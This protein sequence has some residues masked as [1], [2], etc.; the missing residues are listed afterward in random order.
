MSLMS[1]GMA[2]YN[3]YANVKKYGLGS[4]EDHPL[5]KPSVYRTAFVTSFL[6]SCV[7]KQGLPPNFNRFD[8]SAQTKIR[9]MIFGY[10]SCYA[11]GAADVV[12]QPEMDY[13]QKYGDQPSSFAT[14]DRPIERACW[15]YSRLGDVK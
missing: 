13:L 3:A 7:Q 6:N 1:A 4:G 5:A 8:P 12:T 14:K 11:D 2:E 10:C 9:G 15:D